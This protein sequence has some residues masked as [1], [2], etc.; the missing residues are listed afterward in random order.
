[1]PV[2]MAN[3]L[4]LI[5]QSGDFA[6]FALGVAMLAAF[7]LTIA[8]VRLVAR[9]RDRQRGW[10]MLGVAVVLVGNV[11]IWAWPIQAPQASSRHSRAGGN[12]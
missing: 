1:M 5:G 11:L 2:A 10:L 6:T 4:T 8:G 3:G 9:G 12:P 7:V